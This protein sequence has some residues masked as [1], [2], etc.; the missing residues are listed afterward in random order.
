MQQRLLGRRRAG[1][2]ATTGTGKQQNCISDRAPRARLLPLYLRDEQNQASAAAFQKTGRSRHQIYSTAKRTS[3]L[4][5][6]SRLH[7]EATISRQ[8]RNLLGILSDRGVV[9]MPTSA[10]LTTIPATDICVTGTEI[11]KPAR[12]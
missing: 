3:Q 5:R 6:S 4:G 2:S 12:L 10:E 9:F 7:A 8:G 11:P 1:S